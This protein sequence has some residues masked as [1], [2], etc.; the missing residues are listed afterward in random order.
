V[1]GAALMVIGAMLISLTAGASVPQQPRLS[2]DQ[3]LALDPIDPVAAVDAG[4]PATVEEI[5]RRAV[6]W[7]RTEQVAEVS[8]ADLERAIGTLMQTIAD[9]PV[10]TD[11][12]QVMYIAEMTYRLEASC[13]SLSSKDPLRHEYC[14]DTSLPDL[15]VQAVPWDRQA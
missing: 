12:E 7:Y 8:D 4:W 15:D 13:R 14:S 10:G 11:P 9:P 6:D 3:V 1:A 5:E 2:P